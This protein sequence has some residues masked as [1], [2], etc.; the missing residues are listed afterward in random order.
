MDNIKDFANPDKSIQI[1]G[2]TISD[3]NS[4][5]RV[6]IWDS[7]DGNDVIIQGLTTQL[8]LH[9]NQI[10][11]ALGYKPMFRVR[12]ESVMGQDAIKDIKKWF[13]LKDIYD[14][15]L[16]YPN[17]FGYYYHEGKVAINLVVTT[18]KNMA[19]FSKTYIIKSADEFP[20]SPFTFGIGSG[21][22]IADNATIPLTINTQYTDQLN[23]SV[24]TPAQIKS[25]ATMFITIMF[26]E[27]I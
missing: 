14:W 15:N 18:T 16:N 3:D 23:I 4:Y 25:G 10:E 24:C 21:Y 20:Y 2:Q 7:H 27:E 5:S 19:A 26:F 12:S 17:H 1:S 8:Q 22:A 11:K 13:T 9:K 6:A